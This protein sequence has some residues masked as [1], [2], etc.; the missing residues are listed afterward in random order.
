M[1]KAPRPKTSSADAHVKL[2]EIYEQR[3]G[4]RMTQ[5]QFAK[6][7]AIGSPC[8]LTLYLNGGKPLGI[9]A[10][11]R[12][13]KA[14]GC[15]IEDFAPDLTERFTDEVLPFLGN[16]VGKKLRRVAM[17]ALSIPALSSLAPRDAQASSNAA[18]SVYY[19]KRR[20]WLALARRL[21]R[22]RTGFSKISQFA[23]A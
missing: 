22:S 12:F 9:E 21:V 11:A 16:S 5:T 14:L 18:G 23:S 17:I 20:P 1:M 2:R 19:V 7:Y 10:A 15:T 3:I 8:I 13:A 4:A 6:L